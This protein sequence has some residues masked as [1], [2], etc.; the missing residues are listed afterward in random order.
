MNL[1]LGEGEIVRILAWQY[2]NL[3]VVITIVFVPPPVHPINFYRK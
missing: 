2:Y 3:L 1:F